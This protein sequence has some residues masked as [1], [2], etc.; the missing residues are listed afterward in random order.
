MWFR[1]KCKDTKQFMT[2]SSKVKNG[3][4]RNFREGGGGQ[5]SL[6]VQGGQRPKRGPL[7]GPMSLFRTNIP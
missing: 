4:G 7:N 6:V 3:G 5:I 1:K 2:I